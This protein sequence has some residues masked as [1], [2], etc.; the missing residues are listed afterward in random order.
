MKTEVAAIYTLMLLEENNYPSNLAEPGM[1]RFYDFL[2]LVAPAWS[3]L[4]LTSK[5]VAE[6]VLRRLIAD[7]KAGMI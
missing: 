4:R 3:E 2:D 6:I 1:S 7:R 5:E